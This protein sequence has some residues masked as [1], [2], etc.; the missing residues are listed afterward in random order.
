MGDD[1]YSRSPTPRLVAPGPAH[2]YSRERH[3]RLPLVEETAHMRARHQ[4]G[5][6]PSTPGLEG[7][8]E[9]VIFDEICRNI[10]DY[11]QHKLEHEKR[12][13]A[14]LS[15]LDAVQINNLRYRLFA[16]H[17]DHH[18]KEH[19]RAIA[20]L[21]RQAV[22]VEAIG[23][24]GRGLINRDLLEL[25]CGT[26]T[27]ILQLCEAL[28]PGRAERLQ[29]VANDLSDDMKR[30]AREKLAGLPCSIEYSSQDLRWLDLP[31]G[32]FGTVILSQT[33][34]L[35]T[36]EEVVNQERASNYMF[37]DENRHLD[38]KYW[39]ISR[40]WESL[41]PGG[42]FFLIDEWPALLSDR[43]GPLGPGFAYLFNDGLRPVA[44]D[45]FHVSVMEQMGGCRF[46]T[47]L[48]API[49]SKHQMYLMVY[50]KEAGPY[51]GKVPAGPDFAGLRR[52]ASERILEIFRTIEQDFISSMS[53]ANG[54]T[55]WVN[56]LPIGSGTR[57]ITDPREELAWGQEVDCVVI[58]Q[59][60][61]RMEKYD[62]FDMIA[63]AVGA[64]NVGGTLI[65]I[66]EWSPPGGSTHP[67]RQASLKPAY[68]NRF[69]KQMVSAGSVRIPIAD[70][71]ESGM[72]GY[73]YRK[74]L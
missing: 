2:A 5:V 42:T 16:P 38:E 23:F 45:T 56:L 58:D 29:F 11:D 41:A 67:L 44:K 9:Q 62:R 48:K 14:L 1:S 40:A 61:H 55:P 33:L 60:M 6:R 65:I 7:G 12:M 8:S 53:P 37:V 25:S 57:R 64:L 47:Q 3:R 27:V 68:M 22:N 49:D 34:H 73:Q 69:S 54:E 13:R 74:V 17:Y 36:D 70:G 52:S 72:Y 21:L 31:S 63:Y 50:R 15:S 39:T 51:L 30:I 24:G 4:S 32:S 35:I 66:D 28:P 71:F 59:C 19:E 18:M 10:V 20:S 46:V 43:G 26:G